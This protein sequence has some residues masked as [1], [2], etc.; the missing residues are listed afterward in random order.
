MTSN[1]AAFQ[2]FLA[3][4]KK[5]GRHAGELEVFIEASEG[6]GIFSGGRRRILGKAR[7]QAE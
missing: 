6:G 4:A 1:Y 2:K 3:D 7:R 5:V